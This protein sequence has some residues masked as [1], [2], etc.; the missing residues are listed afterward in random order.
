VKL[1]LLCAFGA[2][3]VLGTRAGRERYEELRAMARSASERLET[4]GVRDR[5][6]EASGRLEAYSARTRRSKTMA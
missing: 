3:Y 5:L 6:E 1:T 2:G 4:A